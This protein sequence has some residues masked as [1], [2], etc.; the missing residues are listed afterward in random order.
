MDKKAFSL[1]GGLGNHVKY[2]ELAWPNKK[3]EVFIVPI[4]FNLGKGYLPQES[5][6]PAHWQSRFWHHECKLSTEVQVLVIDGQAVE[7]RNG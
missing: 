3:T 1:E 7:H 6:S 5:K 4:T 2:I